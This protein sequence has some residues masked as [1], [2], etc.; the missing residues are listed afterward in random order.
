MIPYINIIGGILGLIGLILIYM[1]RK[2]FTLRHQNF[3]TAAVVLL[4]ILIVIALCAI[5][6]YVAFTIFSTIP[7]SIETDANKT[8]PKEFLESVIYSILVPV[9]ILGIIGGIANVLLVYEL[10][11]P[12]G[13]KLLILGYVVTAILAVSMLFF[14]PSIVEIAS[15]EKMKPEEV[16]QKISGMTMGYEIL[17]KI[18]YIIYAI[19][20]YIPYK[21][22]I[23]REV[24]ESLVM[25]YQPPLS[26]Y[27]QQY[28]P[29]YY[30][31]Y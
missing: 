10:E 3:V 16:S 7:K 11:N 12:I 13:K 19:A 18:G 4:I 15:Q 21:R 14:I 20:Y 31:Q 30:R 2:A 23:N 9:I 24:P 29:P 5:P 22:I 27:Q 1:G 6:V 28:P 26:P 17:G 8:A 25:P